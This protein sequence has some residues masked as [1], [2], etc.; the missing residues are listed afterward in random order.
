MINVDD[1][2]G[3]IKE[4]GGPCP[5]FSGGHDHRLPGRGALLRPSGVRT[6]LGGSPRSR[7]AL[8]LHIATNR[9]S[10]GM[11]SRI[12]RTRPAL[13]ANAD[14]WV[15]VSLGHMIFTGVLERY[16]RLHV[17]TVEHDSAGAAFLERLDYTYTQRARR[18][19]WYRLRTICCRAISSTAASFSA[20][21]KTRWASETA[22]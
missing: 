13:L 6:I 21:R 7:H 11:P 12:R 17:G 10:P 22:R 16:P 9:P 4:L 19:W 18:D 1:I 2:P 8:S 20:S 14:H 15:R 3:A 5:G